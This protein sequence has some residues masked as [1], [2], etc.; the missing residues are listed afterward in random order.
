MLSMGV[1]DGAGSACDGQLVGQDVSGLCDERGLPV[2]VLEP[3]L[4][5]VDAL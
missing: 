2:L 4:P 3:A 1:L 5:V